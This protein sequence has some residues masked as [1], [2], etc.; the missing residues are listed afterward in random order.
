VT[1]TLQRC[2]FAVCRTL[3][4]LQCTMPTGTAG[5]AAAYATSS[6]CWHCALQLIQDAVLLVVCLAYCVRSRSCTCCLLIRTVLVQCTFQQ[7]FSRSCLR[8]SLVITYCAMLIKRMTC[9]RTLTVALP[10]HCACSLSGLKIQVE[11][12]CVDSRFCWSKHWW[13]QAALVAC[14]TAETAAACCHGFSAAAR[15]FT[16]A[17]A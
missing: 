6:A 11:Q 1:V 3:D 8:E 15:G 14:M 10:M 13:H 2:L 4:Q 12:E 9:L 17:D 5:Q 16:H 7:E